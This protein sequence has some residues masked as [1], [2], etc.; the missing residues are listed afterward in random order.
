MAFDV[1][2]ER[3]EPPTLRIT[4]VT[5]RAKSVRRTRELFVGTCDEAS[6]AAAVAIA[7]AVT[8][9]EELAEPARSEGVSSA[10]VPPMEQPDSQPPA[11]TP[12]QMSFGV[13]G[14][15]DHGALP[16]LS[17]GAEG[18]LSA[19]HGALQITALGAYFAPRTA[20]L[21]DGRGGE[22]S[23]ALGGLLV[24][25][26]HRKGRLV[27]RACAGAELGVLRAKGI[28]L[29]Q[30]RL[31]SAPWQALRGQVAV[32]WEI[33]PRVLLVAELALT[34]PLAQP[35]FLVDGEDRVH[36]VGPVTE[37]GLLGVE[38]LF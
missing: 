12:W 11:P 14:A 29:N 33:V 5:E 1:R 30:P 3:A 21:A 34:L 22:F 2:V 19:S 8:S 31:G 15:L 13:F 35:A 36:T 32:G 24:C 10:A 23:L 4:I 25:G 26:Q 9:S 37:R 17:A 20:Q 38:F 27:L 7:M 6:D 18:T 28:G 16:T